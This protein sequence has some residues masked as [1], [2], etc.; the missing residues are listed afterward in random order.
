MPR[1]DWQAFQEAH[2]ISHGVRLTFDKDHTGA[3]FVQLRDAHVTMS[4][5]LGR[6][7]LAGRYTLSISRESGEPEIICLFSNQTDAE[8]VAAAVAGQQLKQTG[9]D[10]LRRLAESDYEQILERAGPPQ[11]GGSRRRCQGL[12]D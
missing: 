10:R 6:L 4:R 12:G 2:P 9:R 5:L 8:A 1:L 3:P 11:R 7:D